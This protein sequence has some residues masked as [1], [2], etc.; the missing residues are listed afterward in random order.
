MTRL[1][2]FS[3]PI[4]IGL[5]TVL[6]LR[7]EAAS[8]GGGGSVAKSLRSEP[9]CFDDGSGLDVS[10]LMKTC[11]KC[12]ADVV[13]EW[14]ASRHATSWTSPVFRAQIAKLPDKGESCARCHAPDSILLTGPGEVPRAR[15]DDRELGVNCTTCHMDGKKYHGPHASKGHGGIVVRED[16]QKSDFCAGC[17]G[18][19]EINAAHDQWTSYLKSPSFED[20][21]SCQ[22]CHMPEIDRKMV[23][24]K[25]KLRNTQEARVCR[26]HSFE[27]VHVAEIAESAAGIEAKIEEATLV[28]EVMA[29]T[30]HSLPASEGREVR[31][32]T[33]FTDASGKEVGKES[34]VFDYAKKKVI[35]PSAPTILK[36]ALPEGAAKAKVSLSIV[37]QAVEGRAVEKVIPIM[38]TEVAR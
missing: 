38:S 22:D 9:P 24:A 25:R 20:G 30:G 21:E 31:V 33:S 3:S 29:L 28:V 4:V 13:E 23:K 32:E 36:Q 14:S 27:G 18:H 5:L 19:P 2:F 35:D 16:Y 34:V 8:P 12:H 6:F 11:K 1:F 10:R 37:L 17:H 7:G 15:K 26:V